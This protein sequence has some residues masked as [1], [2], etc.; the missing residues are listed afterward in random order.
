MVTSPTK[1]T[2]TL[3]NAILNPYPGKRPKNPE[4]IYDMK[5]MF[6]KIIT[7]QPKLPT[8]VSF[9]NS[10]TRQFVDYIEISEV[11]A[12]LPGGRGCVGRE[13]MG[14]KLLD[15]QVAVYNGRGVKTNPRHDDSV[16]KNYGFLNLIG[17]IQYKDGKE[18]N[19]NIP[20]E[21]SGV[22]GLRTG[23]STMALID[24]SQTNTNN[25][26]G[27][28]LLNLVREIQDILFTML[29]I[30]AISPPSFGMIN[31]M[32]NIYTNEKKSMRPKMTNFVKVA[33]QLQ[34]H[35]IMAAHYQK[36]S[37]PWLKVQQQAPA[38]M[39]AIYKPLSKIDVQKNYVK[40]IDDLP[41]VS[42][43]PYGHVE[44]LGAKS[45]S[46][47]IRAYNIITQSVDDIDISVTA[48]INSNTVPKIVKSKKQLTTKFNSSLVIF[49]RDKQVII[50]KKE[51]S[52]LPKPILTR[53]L[54][55]YGLP[56]KGTKATMCERLISVL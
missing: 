36:A 33:K 25:T 12:C 24:P 23:A 51:C 1:I 7:D 13:R 6:E 28:N 45:I 37:M 32:F 4:K 42:L 49:K 47:M 30:R 56:T 26:R 21:P 50:N 52:T 3:F 10:S 34:K 11:Y 29:G 8:R 19:L 27:N 22:V 39:K 38:V 5:V 18:S 2:T 54:A 43:S 14:R 40:T 20:V 44:I 48:P 35:S 15:R 41:T 31:G 9:E 17:K 55:S 16:S 46:S 53:I